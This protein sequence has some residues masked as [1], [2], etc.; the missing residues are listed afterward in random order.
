MEK[1]LMQAKSPGNKDL[2]MKTELPIALDLFHRLSKCK[3]FPVVSGCGL[4]IREC[5][6]SA[7]GEWQCVNLEYLI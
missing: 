4:G 5:H 2:K 3:L 1:H 7:N 6:L